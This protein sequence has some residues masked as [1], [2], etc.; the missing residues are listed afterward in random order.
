[1]KILSWNVNGLRACERKG[2]LDFLHAEQPEIL[3]LQ[4]VRARP[5]QLS[6]AVLAPPGYHVAFSPAARPG[7]SGVALYSRRPP[8]R[9]ETSLGQARFDDEGRLQL[10]RF[11]RLLVANVYFPNGNGKERD[12]SR[13]PYKLEFYR[14][15]E[16]RLARMRRGGL[17]VLVLGDFNTAHKAI[18]L[19]RPKQNE[20]TSGFLPEERE[21]IDRW[22]A[23]GWVD[24]FRHFEKG[25]GHYSWWS[26]RQGA[27][28]RNVGWRIDYVMASPAAMNFVRRAFILPEVMGSDNCPVGVEVD[29]AICG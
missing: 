6:E 27:R 3:G 26:Q 2:F 29:P 23:A 28:A 19:A 7:Y 14:T 10:A 13:V 24:T 9:V 18:D 25:P 11:G 22:I 20:K 4:E 17:R 1:M 15:L 5:E 12:N 16:A 21:E 8:D